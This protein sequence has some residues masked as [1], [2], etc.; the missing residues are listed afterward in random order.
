M[1]STSTMVSPDL[2]KQ[3]RKPPLH[4]RKSEAIIMRLR[5]ER[6]RRYVHFQGQCYSD[7]YPNIAS[8]GFQCSSR[9]GC[10]WT[11]ASYAAQFKEYAAAIVDHSLGDTPNGGME[12]LFQ[13]CAFQAPRHI[14]FNETPF[15]NVENA[16]ELGLDTTGM[17]KT[18]ADH[19]VRNA[20]LLP[21]LSFINTCNS[22]WDQRVTGQPMQLSRTT[23]STITT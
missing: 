20:R 2:N 3:C 7:P 8:A 17:V 9:R 11:I 6:S 23:C 1:V 13:G 19:E 22:T 18:V 12:P 5:W 21:F 14:G 4:T 10:N 16:L 15:W